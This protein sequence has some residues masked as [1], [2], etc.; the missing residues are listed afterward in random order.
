[1][2]LL[3]TAFVVTL[4]VHV[5]YVIESPGNAEPV[6]ELIT[7]PPDHSYPTVGSH[8]FG[9]RHGQHR[10]DGVRQVA[11]RALVDQTIVPAKQVLGTQT[12][13]END[14]LNQV[15]MRQSKDA[16]V[17]VALDK[18]GYHVTPTQTGALI[19]S[20]DHGTPADGMLQVGDTIVAVDGQ[21]VAS[22]DELSR[23][24]ARTS[25]A[26]WCS[27]ASKIPTAIGAMTTVT[28]TNHPDKPGIGFPRRRR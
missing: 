25:Q 17:L 15:L 21:P 2:S 11:G 16:A 6:Q 24:S 26:T 23:C 28:L 1:M 3:T 13:Q 18:L 27:S 10:R 14:R 7:V 4:L 5:P 19:V 20:I 12:P 9:D 8:Q 22:R